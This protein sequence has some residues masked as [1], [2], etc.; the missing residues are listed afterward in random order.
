MKQLTVWLARYS[1]LKG[2]LSCRPAVN[3]S[4]LNSK[5]RQIKKAI[6]QVKDQNI[7]H[8]P[9]PGQVA[10]EAGNYEHHETSS[11]GGATWW[12]EAGHH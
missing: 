6:S 8:Q 2:V 4:L 7:G 10:L 1:L 11:G 12:T 3:S 9:C 5:G